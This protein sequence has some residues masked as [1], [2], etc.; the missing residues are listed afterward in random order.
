MGTEKIEITGTNIGPAERV[1]PYV[2]PAALT[3]V[4]LAA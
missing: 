1:L 3:E 2:P 4:Q